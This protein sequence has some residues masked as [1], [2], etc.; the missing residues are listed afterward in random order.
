MSHAVS[1]EFAET[2]IDLEQIIHLQKVNHVSQ[3][4]SLEKNSNGFVTVLHTI[5]LLIQM[6]EAAPQIITKYN[7]AVVAYALV[8]LKEFSALIPTLVPM[9]DLFEQLNYLGK[10][11]TTYNYYVMGQICI[12]EKYRG[13][14]LFEKLYAKHKE[15]HSNKFDLCLTEVSTSNQRSM[16]AHERVGFKILHTFKDETDEWNILVWDW[17]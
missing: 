7:G 16:K 1:I 12:D 10:S 8:M 6:N 15:T 11:L 4:T 5:A 9:F 2:Q 3:L 14:G 17:R 13:Q